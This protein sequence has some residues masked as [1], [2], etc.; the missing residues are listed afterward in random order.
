[1][2]RKIPLFAV[3]I[4]LSIVHSLYSQISFDFEVALEGQSSQIEGNMIRDKEGFLWFCYYGGVARYDGSEVRYYVPGDNSLSG[5]AT[6]SIAMDQDGNIWILTKDNGLNRYNKDTDEFTQFTHD[7]GN[8]NSISSNLSDSFGPHRLFVDHKNRLLLGSMAGFDIYDIEEDRF[9][10]YVHDPDN[11][12]SLSSNNVTAV[13]EDSRGIIWIGTGGGGLNRFD[14]STN[15]WTRFSFKPGSE[16]GPASNTI[17]SL[18]E[19]SR[20]ALWFGTWDGG[21][22]R[23]DRETD[24]FVHYRSDPEKP[25]GLGDNKIFSLFEDS[26]GNIYACHRDSDVAGFEV[27]DRERDGFLKFTSSDKNSSS[28]SSNYISSVYEDPDTGIL[29]AL[30]T[31]NGKIDKYDRKSRKFNL[32][33]S[34]PDDPDSISNSLIVVMLEDKKGN[35]WISTG[36]SLN[37]YDKKTEKFS[38]YPYL[39]IDPEMG[40]FTSTMCW[41]NDYQMWLLSNRGVL[42]LFDIRTL[43]PVRQ[44]KHDPEDENS[45]MVSTSAGGHIIK[46]RD[47]EHLLWMGLSSGLEKFNTETETFTH[48]TYLPFSASITQGTVWSVYDDGRG[49]LW[50]SAFGGLSI[51]EKATETFTSYIPDPELP[52]SIGF[53]KQSRVFEDSFG[54]VWVAGFEN[55]MDLFDRETGIFQHFNKKTGFP[56]TGINL[57]IQEDST[58]HLWIGTTDNGLIKFN[59]ERKEVVSVF[60]KDDGLQDNHFWRSFKMSDGQMWFGGGFGVNHFYPEQVTLNNTIVPVYLTSFTQSGKKLDLGIAPERLK[61]VTLGWQE[62][63]FEFQFAALNYTKPEKNRFAYM[64]EGRDK[65]WYYSDDNPSG[66]YTGL[67]GGSYTLRL[68]AANNDGLWNEDGYSLKINVIPPFWRTKF[69]YILA[70]LSLSAIL[71]LVMFYVR[72]LHDEIRERKASDKK[73][74]H[75]QS[76]LSNIIDSM[77]SI[78]I[79]V[80]NDGYITQWN[81]T[82][83]KK[84]NISSKKAYGKYIATVLPFLEPRREVIE[85]S[86]HSKEVNQIPRIERKVGSE[87]IFEEIIVYPLTAEG[88][89]GAVIRIDDVSEKVRMEE[90]MIQSEKML[91]IG[92]LAAGMAHEINN[93]LAGML[94]TANV[95]SKRLGSRI[96]MIAN[97]KAAEEVG[98]PVESIRSFMEKRGILRMINSINESGNRVAQIVHNMLSFA[99]KSEG[100]LSSHQMTNI[101]DKSIMLASND[102]DI[103]KNHDFKNI[104]ILK[105]YEDGLPDIIC[106]ESKIQQ[107]ILNILQNGAQAMDEAETEN[108]QFTV[109]L[110]MDKGNTKVCMSF[111][112]NGPGMKENVRKKVFDPFFTT[113]PPGSGTGLGLSVAYYIV[114]VNHD[115]EMHVESE[116]G[117]GTT[118][119]IF[120]PIRSN[121]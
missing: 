18:L 97:V 104:S 32:E 17:W 103:Q 70:I 48:Y 53:T 117:K 1:L 16:K 36:D 45:M 23:Y 111:E 9:Y 19:D 14:E 95:M 2:F 46:D 78:L 8:E 114:T 22:S 25:M 65:Q 31:H 77:P 41:E 49:Y 10:H 69:F 68:K 28:I 63:Y 47:N 66:R 116:P 96:D 55:G 12:N 105:E 98:I 73:L 86:I 88:M 60:S 21:L 93:P 106:D 57:T 87:I 84:T 44:Y 13:M 51:L 85:K 6:I 3:I 72:K 74:Q 90:M 7:P 33:R 38:S 112:D 29:W 61:E 91:S 54:N 64:L 118:F 5:P 40:P 52:D 27:Y 76:Y 26:S 108:P 83:A 89:E 121:L 99:R 15:T 109:R 101:I 37:L 34:N 50:I 24:T 56:A 42:T 39:D 62:N 11:P 115:G 75:M 43:K 100:R 92:G 59:I 4:A 82:A 79:A 35:L 94:Q 113:K 80:D 119:I 110:K 67:N 102:F 81:N 71:L 30:N 58:G 20:G 120:L 107:V